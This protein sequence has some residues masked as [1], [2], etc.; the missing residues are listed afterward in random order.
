[1]SNEIRLAQDPRGY[2]TLLTRQVDLL[3]VIERATDR[4]EKRKSQDEAN[5]VRLVEL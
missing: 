1:M 3:Q 5:V 2:V 4:E